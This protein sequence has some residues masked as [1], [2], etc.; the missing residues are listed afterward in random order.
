MTTYL[1][2]LLASTRVAALLDKQV[3][4]VCLPG[5]LDQSTDCLV[6]GGN[7]S[8]IGLEWG[9]AS[10]I[11]VKTMPAPTVNM[12]SFYSKIWRVFQSPALAAV[13]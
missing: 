9:A 13:A 10:E 5:K 12:T 6:D 11:R 4:L 3:L 7:L 8:S 1:L 2:V